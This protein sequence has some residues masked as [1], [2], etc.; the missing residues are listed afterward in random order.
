MKFI[1][2]SDGG[3]EAAA[4]EAARVLRSGGIVLYPTDTL[5]GLG[6]DALN[7][8]A[9]EKLRHLKGREKKKPM[10]IIVPDVAA[11]HTHATLHGEAHT[12]AAKHLP[13]A[14]TLVLPAKSHIPETLTLNG[15]VGIRVPSDPF[16][17]ALADAFGGPYTATSANRAGRTTESTPMGIISSFGHASH[18]IDLVIDDGPRA[19]GTP[20]TVVRYTDNAPAILRE[21]MLS[22]SELGF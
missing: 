19:G 3:I 16:A 1:R 21:G 4:T 18:L 20:S 14:L 22:R 10:S 2:I 17:L 5:Y 7:P 9:V 8:V 6:V 13:G 11:L 12:L 15:A